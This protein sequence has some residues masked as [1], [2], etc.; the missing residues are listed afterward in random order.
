MRKPRALTAGDRLAIVAPA[1]PFTREEFDS[2]LREIRRL[3]FVPVHDESV[4]AR[5]DLI[6]GFKTQHKSLRYMRDYFVRLGAGGQG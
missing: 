2:G 5:L 3:G 4:F 1:S 6:A